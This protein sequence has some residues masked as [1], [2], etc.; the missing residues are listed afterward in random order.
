M[1]HIFTQES[2]LHTIGL[3]DKFRIREKAV[4]LRKFL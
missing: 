4:I 1:V 3:F 2:K